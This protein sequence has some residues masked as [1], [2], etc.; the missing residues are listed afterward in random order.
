MSNCCFPPRITCPSS[1]GIYDTEYLEYIRNLLSL[2]PQY[3][4][5]AFVSLHQDVWSRY[6]GGSG[7]PAWTL[8]TVGFDL[9]ELESTGAAWLKGVRGG[10][11]LEEERGLWPCGY[12][13]VRSALFLVN[14][15]LNRVFSSASRRDYGVSVYFTYHT[16]YAYKA[17]L[18][19]CFWAGDAFAPKLLTK[20]KHGDAISVQQFLQDAYLDMSE[21][22]VKAVGDLEG[23]V[24]FEVIHPSNA[25]HPS[26]DFVR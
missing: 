6:S 25:N 5:I 10:G 13:K 14:C 1:R 26:L 19:T 20:G 22:V 17:T 4:I 24:G 8:E 12:Q 9:H 16:Q 7:A 21:M 3:G 23:V 15:N 2:L 11:H 18:R